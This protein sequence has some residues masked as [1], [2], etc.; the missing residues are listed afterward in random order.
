MS[1]VQEAITALEEAGLTEYEARCFVALTRI[2]KGTAKEISDVAD[3]PRSRVYDTIERLNE[4]GLVNT[5]ASE[6][7][8]FKS[9]SVDT[10]CQRLQ[11]NY[12]S[13]INSAEN[14]LHQVEEPDS[15]D[16]EGMWA[17]NQHEQV[18]DRIVTFVD[19]AEES[20]YYL[21][22][23]DD[24]FD[25]RIRSHLQSATERGVRVVLE[26][27]TD[28]RKRDLQEELP[29]ATILVSTDLQPTKQVYTEWPGQLL[30]VDQRSIVAAGIKETDLPDV[31]QE[32]A[33]WTYGRD[34]GFAVWVRELLASRLSNRDVPPL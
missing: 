9:V 33:V 12:D 7:R 2:S 18:T 21:V 8:E 30:M 31:H 28:E 29:E 23:A 25:R 20:I 24:V 5:Q 16:D 17:I 3:I 15:M 22:A 19:D 1:K 27:P 4:K 14:A 6:P 26:L 13:R 34:H 11:E 10:A 32:T